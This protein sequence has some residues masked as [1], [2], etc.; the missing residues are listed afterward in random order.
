ME[1]E[2]LG[3]SRLVKL[4]EEVS[5]GIKVL[6]HAETIKSAVGWI[7][8]NPQPDLFFMDIELADGQC[9]EIFNQAE[10][11][12]P[13]IFTTSYAEYALNAF[14]VNSIDYLLKPVTKEDLSRSLEKYRHLKKQFGENNTAQI[15]IEKLITELHG[16]RPQNEFRK[17][18]L[19][20]QGQQLVRIEVSEIAWFVADGKLCF[21]R[22]WIN[23]RYLLNYTLEQLTSLLDPD[24]FFRIN[25]KYIAH[26]KSIKAINAYFSGK[27]ILQLMP[28]P[29][30]NDVIV[31]REKASEFKQWMGK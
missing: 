24:E 3:L 17:R 28:A 11:L 26:V 19:V 29:E 16:L 5:P 21:L 20:K 31:S 4:L 13:I 8:N 22:T 27:L 7:Q 15:I 10:V 9:F 2:R 30:A 12:A 1:D 14:K 6:G 18:F 25:R 23:Q